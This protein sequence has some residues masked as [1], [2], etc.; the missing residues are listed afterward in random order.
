MGSSGEESN[1]PSE[2]IIATQS[3]GDALPVG[4][5]SSAIAD[6]PSP[7]VV[8]SL[9]GSPMGPAADLLKNSTNRVSRRSPGLV[10]RW[11]LALEGRK[12]V[13]VTSFVWRRVRISDYASPSGEFGIPLKHP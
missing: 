12:I 5:D 8:S 10:P 2:A 9:S 11:Q 4:T 13:L 3:V 6:S 7:D 1:T